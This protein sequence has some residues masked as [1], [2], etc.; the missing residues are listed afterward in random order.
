MRETCTK[1]NHETPHKRLNRVTARVEALAEA[2]QT[3]VL[4]SEKEV[5]LEV[6]LQQLY[7]ALYRTHSTKVPTDEI[8]AFER[9]LVNLENINRPRLKVRLW[10]SRVF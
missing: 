1:I 9:R 5:M 6:M 2:K 7:S 10:Q 4:R 3:R 8:T